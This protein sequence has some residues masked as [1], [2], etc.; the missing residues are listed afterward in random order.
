MATGTGVTTV[1]LNLRTGPG[2]QFAV[3]AVLPPQ[4]AVQVLA[5]QGDWLQVTTAVGQAGFVHR[6]FVRLESQGT[7]PGLLRARPDDAQRS[8]IAPPGPLAP[9]AAQAITLGANASSAERQAANIWNKYGGLLAELS[10]K[11]RIDPGAAVT[12]LAI[13]SGGRGFAA[14]GRL[15]IRFENHLFFRQW[16][17]QHAA[18]F[19]RHFSFN[20]EKNWLDHRWRQFT[21]RPFAAFH[22]TQDGEWQVFSF[23][24]SLDDT[25]AKLSISMGG[26]QIVG[27]NYPT[28][29]YE[30]VHQM[31][32]AFSSGERQQIIG[33][34]DFVQ[35]AGRDSRRV[36]ALQAGDFTT[37]AS[38]YNG[39]GQA[40]KYG[41]LMQSV[42]DTFRRLKPN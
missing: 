35:G 16:G 31:F 33:F 5:E 23:A 7:D 27:F 34:F 41:S 4:T 19:N 40:A 30:S 25:A 10:G 24:R 29:G 32:D 17:R 3:L 11:L 39:P 36:L 8:S 21:N 12:V 37:F 20:P 9:P 42:F 2:T 6:A 15:I 28:L 1:D 14:D 26:P 13:E 22:G 18:V 38:L